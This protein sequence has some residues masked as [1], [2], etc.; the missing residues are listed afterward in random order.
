MA[1]VQCQAYIFRALL[2]APLICCSVAEDVVQ[3]AACPYLRSAKASNYQAVVANH[4]L[5]PLLLPVPAGA[6]A[7]APQFPI[8]FPATRHALVMIPL[9]AVTLLLEQY[10]LPVGGTRVIR[11][12]RLAGYIGMRIPVV[13]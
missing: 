5:L 12:N 2:S 13:L 10:N 11:I 1:G 4:P 3:P 7:G 8:S 6:V 9:P